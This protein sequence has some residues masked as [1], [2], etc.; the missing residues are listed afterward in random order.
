MLIFLYLVKEQI[1]VW[2]NY[3]IIFLLVT[4]MVIMGDINGH[5]SILDYKLSIFNDADETDFDVLYYIVRIEA[6]E[7]IEIM[8]YITTFLRRV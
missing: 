6:L 8:Q 7:T 1:L 2:L 4:V 5:R 3:R